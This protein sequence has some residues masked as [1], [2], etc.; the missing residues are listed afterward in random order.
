MKSTKA[1][2]YID[3]YYWLHDFNIVFSFDV[4]IS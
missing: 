3:V 2:E 4:D 1:Y